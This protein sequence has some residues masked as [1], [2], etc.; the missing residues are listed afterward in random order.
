MHDTILDFNQLSGF[1]LIGY[2]GTLAQ[3]KQY[4]AIPRLLPD[5]LK[6]VHIA[7]DY[8]HNF[9]YASPR[10][11][12]S[13]AQ[14]LQPISPNSLFDLSFNYFADD[15]HVVWDINDV[16]VWKNNVD[17]DGARISIQR[18][19]EPP[20]GLDDDD[21]TSLWQKVLRREHPYDGAAHSQDDETDIDAVV[22]PAD[23]IAKPAVLYTAFYAENGNHPQDFM[24]AKLDLLMKNTQVFEH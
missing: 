24:K 17:G 6:N 21:L 8:G 23:N 9:A 12:F 14:E 16:H 2:G 22:T 5:V 13:F 10:V 15:G 18:Y 11:A 20:V 4:L 1:V 7:F 19:H 3:W